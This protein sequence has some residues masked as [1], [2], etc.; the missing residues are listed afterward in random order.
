VSGMEMYVL[1]CSQICVVEY[2]YI[3]SLDFDSKLKYVD[4]FIWVAL[5]DVEG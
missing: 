4:V 3:K 1:M 5:F 2:V